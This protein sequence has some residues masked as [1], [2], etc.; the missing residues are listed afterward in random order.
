MAKSDERSGVSSK[1]R[2]RRVKRNATPPSAA[3][4]GRF[5]PD[6]QKERHTLEQ[7][8]PQK[9]LTASV[10]HEEAHALRKLAGKAQRVRTRAPRGSDQPYG[11][12]AR[13]GP[14]AGEV[15]TPPPPPIGGELEEI[16]LLGARARQGRRR[17][18][19]TSA[20]GQ[21]DAGASR[22]HEEAKQLARTPL[23]SLI[24]GELEEI[25]LFGRRARQNQA[26]RPGE[27]KG[28]RFQNV[29]DFLRTP[30]MFD[31]RGKELGTSSTAEEIEARVEEVRYQI[32]VMRS[33]MAV[34]TE[35][36]EVL[37]KAQQQLGEDR[38]NASQS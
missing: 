4:R 5:G 21:S 34:L 37:E 16:N 26:A 19:Q 20:F 11:L 35:E 29:Q 36:L 14:S 28:G 33:L 32:E 24:P 12:S 17:T 22:E 18:R 38:H 9:P 23:P 3:A 7:H 15:R 27:D 6:R 31:L 2:V 25:N 13:R 10:Q 30:N 8:T 1:S